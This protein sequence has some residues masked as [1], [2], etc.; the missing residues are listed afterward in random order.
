LVVVA[1]IV[2]AYFVTHLDDEIR[3]EVERILAS[4]YDHLDV[5]VGDA[6]LIE[7][8]GIEVRRL[9]FRSPG[10]QPGTSP[11]LEIEEVFLA[12]PV[13]INQL[14]Q[15][16][17]PLDRVVLHRPH[18]RATRQHDGSW[19]VSDLLPLPTS[20]ASDVEVVVKKGVV[21][22]ACDPRSPN[23]R[24]TFREVTSVVRPAPPAAAASK[25]RNRPREY[26]FGVSA[27]SSLCKLIRLSGRF[28]SDGRASLAGNLAELSLTGRDL[29][30]LPDRVGGAAGQLQQLRGTLALK[31][32]ELRPASN[33]SPSPQFT[34]NVA[35][36]GV[37]IHHSALPDPITQ[38]S[39]EIVASSSGLEAPL[40]A[41]VCGGARF[42]G[43]LRRGGWI[44]GSPLS[45]SG[46]VENFN[47]DERHWLMLPA[48]LRDVWNRY[49]PEGVVDLDLHEIT[50]DGA[51]VVPHVNIACRDAALSA[52]TISYRL[53]HVRGDVEIRPLPEAPRE[54]ATLVVK[55]SGEAAGKRPVAIDAAY[56]VPTHA[57]ASRPEVYPVGSVR[58]T[59]HRVLVEE[60]LLAALPEGPCRFLTDLRV[61][62]EFDFAWQAARTDPRVAEPQ[63][64]LELNLQGGSV[65]YVRFPYPLQDV[66]GKVYAANGN[67]DFAGLTASAGGGN[68]TVNGSLRRSQA[69]LAHEGTG[70]T[71]DHDGGHPILS[72]QIACQRLA[73][74][75]T[76]YTALPENA[77]RAWDAVAPAGQIDVTV[78]Y[79]QALGSGAA[80][81]E[82]WIVPYGQTVSIRPKFFPCRIDHLQGRIH[83]AGPEIRFY[84]MSG[85]RG[86]T[87]IVAGGT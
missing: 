58:V 63:K 43:K 13:Q 23:S 57:S 41:G 59:G 78:N 62:G 66:R 2:G 76:L 6:R 34:A 4:H 3:R 40:L 54:F 53:R 51:H 35:C 44:Q 17:P 56:T 52:D 7:G 73:L 74:D 55:L 80:Q 49:H 75:P 12:C 68:V 86:P 82:H 28:D 11:I 81:I 24:I 36:E 9:E 18:L 79:R 65:N 50:F 21:E 42:T 22:L 15:G 30:A 1:V 70:R 87:Q 31:S 67:W 39:G 46:R 83:F 8:R 33:G 10:A 45:V 16:F 20:G 25:N 5:R 48:P 37:E 29:E 72:L 14:L 32:V 69:G 77:Q 60:N 26:A 47:L 84:E 27:A 71:T 64:Q 38:L 19:D 61:Q 85:Q